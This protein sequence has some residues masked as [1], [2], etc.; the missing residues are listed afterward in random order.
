MGSIGTS[1]TDLTYIWE[2]YLAQEKL[3]SSIR[4]DIANNS[5][6]MFFKSGGNIFATDE[7]NR[8]AFANM[9][10]EEENEE[11]A[12]FAAKNM[13]EGSIKLFNK[14]DLDAIKVINMEDAVKE[15]TNK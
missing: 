12:R 4:E 9:K 10:S 6:I 1:I 7:A 3:E 15:L 13:K 8:I 5:L 11:D 2:N 14:Q